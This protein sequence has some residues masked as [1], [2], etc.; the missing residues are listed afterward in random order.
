MTHLELR[1]LL[2]WAMGGKPN[3]DARDTWAKF[4]KTEA[5][6]FFMNYDW[7]KQKT[8]WEKSYVDER[9]DIELGGTFGTTFAIRPQID[10]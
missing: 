7:V 3:F 4:V 9:L 5:E 2:L 8:F 6:S 1:A 10:K